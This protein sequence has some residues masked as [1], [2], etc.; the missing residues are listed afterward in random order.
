MSL[1]QDFLS[2]LGGCVALFFADSRAQFGLTLLIGIALG[3]LC[4]FACSRYSRLWNL[5][6]RV[7]LTHHVFCALAAILTL[8]FT[9]V[10][11]ALRYTKEAAFLSVQAWEQQI[12]MDSNWGNK[13]FTAV[14]YKVKSTGKEN[15]TG[16]PLPP[17]STVPM[18]HPETRRLV[19]ASYAQASVENF[20]TNR[21]FLSKI[22]QAHTEVPSR[23]L[24][25]DVNAFFAKGGAI[26]DAGDAVALVAKNIKSQ[27]DEQ[28]PRVVTMFRLFAVGLFLC[29]Q[30]IAFG[31]VG[32][33]AYKD[34][35][36]AT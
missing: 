26:Y 1:A 20:N 23:V 6:Y 13:I 19:A 21:P 10:F 36:V 12:N 34:L 14:W 15:Y 7:T 8:L 29:V 11:A 33:A 28:V 31:L 16:L 18:N 22:L 24:D 5:R 27:L 2:L 35:K 32:F 3:A 9:V 4:W 17:N 30:L 25:A